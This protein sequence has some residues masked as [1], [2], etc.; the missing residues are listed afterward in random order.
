MFSDTSLNCGSVAKVF[1]LL[2]P[3]I[4]FVPYLNIRETFL[5]LT[6]INPQVISQAI[7]KPNKAIKRL[8]S[9]FLR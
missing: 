8:V 2:L 7:R 3:D 5:V 9:S 4:L 1:K 6:L